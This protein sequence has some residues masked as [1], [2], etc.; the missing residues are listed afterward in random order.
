MLKNSLKWVGI[1]LLGLLVVALIGPFLVPIPP[2]K[3]LTSVDAIKDADSQFMEVNGIRVHYKKAGQGQPVV[4]LL[5][6][7]GASVF[8]WREVI[9]PLAQ[10]ATVIAYDRPAFGLTDRPMPGEWSGPSPYSTSAQSDLLIGLMDRLGIES[11]VLVGNSAGGTVA[12][13]TALQ[14]PQR[15]RGLVLVDAAIYSGAPSNPILQLLF[16]TPQL[17]RLGPLL[18][19]SISDSGDNTI[20]LAWHD[21]GRVTPEIIEGYRKPLQLPN[22]D[23]ALWELTRANQPLELP[24]RLTDLKLPV[25]VVTGDDDRIVPTADSLRL[26]SEISG[27]RLAVFS[28]CGHVPQEECPDQFLRA[29]DSFL[30]ELK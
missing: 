8:S 28:A 20:R 9:A 13:L 19:R 16:Q 15:V 23:R 6:G 17:N 22:W 14:Y 7:F 5:H 24:R 26:A 30:T 10:K 29:V 1:F 3:D 4:I 2:L 18:V 11:A 21:P 25:L 12:T 27:A